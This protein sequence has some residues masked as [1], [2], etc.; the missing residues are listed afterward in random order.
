MAMDMQ[1]AKPEQPEQKKPITVG[2]LKDA[3][4][5]GINRPGAPGGRE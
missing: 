1:N 4:N 5:T 2:A 3:A